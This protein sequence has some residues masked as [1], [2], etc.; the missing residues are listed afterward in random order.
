MAFLCILSVF[1]FLVGI[2]CFSA[3]FVIVKPGV[4]NLLGG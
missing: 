1:I 2:V 4:D 3:L